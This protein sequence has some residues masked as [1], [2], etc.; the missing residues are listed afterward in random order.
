MC[1]LLRSWFVP[2]ACHWLTRAST[3]VANGDGDPH[4]HVEVNQADVR[5][6]N[7]GDPVTGWSLG[8]EFTASGQRITQ[9]WS[10]TWSQSGSRVTAASL[11][12]NGNLPTNGSASIGFTGAWSSSNPVATNVTL[13][14][15]SCDGGII[16]TTAPRL[17]QHV[18]HPRLHR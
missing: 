6:T 3:P 17:R 2:L 5:I 1:W 7:L 16:P 8:F 10:A 12:W 13:N 14:S 18:H 11:A 4:I 9:G 15:V